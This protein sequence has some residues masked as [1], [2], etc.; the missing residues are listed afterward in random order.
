MR[1]DTDIR[2]Q[3]AVDGEKD[4]TGVDVNRCLVG[5]PWVERES[6]E[7]RRKAEFEG[8]EIREDGSK[9]ELAS[10]LS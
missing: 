10:S 8:A 4:M 5:E 6:R 2:R 9:E 1:N 7:I 3:F